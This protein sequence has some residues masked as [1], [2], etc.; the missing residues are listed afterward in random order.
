VGFGGEH[1]EV[2]PVVPA[3]VD[4]VKTID[5]DTDAKTA[6]SEFLRVLESAGVPSLLTGKA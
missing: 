5:K 1:V 2:T 3:L 4:L 6:L